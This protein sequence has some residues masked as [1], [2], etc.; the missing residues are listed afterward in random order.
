MPTTE[1]EWQEVSKEF[2][3]RWDFPN[4]LGALD[5]KHIK[6]RAPHSSGSYFFNYKG[7]NSI[8]LLA[9]VDAKYKFLYINVGTNGRISDGGVLRESFLSKAIKTN[10]V[11]F[12][13]DVP[14]PGRIMKVPYVIIADD[15]FPLCNRILKP[16]PGQS[17][18]HDCQIFNY[19]YHDVNYMKIELY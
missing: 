17:L 6:F 14:L 12:P 13:D 8:V 4:C 5:G 19:R 1:Q 16:F 11:N 9:L 18:T 7:E 3:L 10:C 15:A 2:Y